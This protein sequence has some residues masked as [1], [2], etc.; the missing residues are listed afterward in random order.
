MSS[1]PDCN[2][3]CQKILLDGDLLEHF[4]TALCDH[5]KQ[6][7]DTGGRFRDPDRV[8]KAIIIAENATTK[9]LKVVLEEQGYNGVLPDCLGG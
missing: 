9:A 8:I 3:A 1:P 6:Y 4:A 2:P 7:R 5:I